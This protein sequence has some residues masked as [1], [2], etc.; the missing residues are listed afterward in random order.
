MTGYWAI[1]HTTD[2]GTNH[3]HPYSVYY[4]SEADVRDTCRLT[5]GDPNCKVVFVE[6]TE[7]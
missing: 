6:I 2:C 7:Q 4:Y 3:L 5:C 1:K